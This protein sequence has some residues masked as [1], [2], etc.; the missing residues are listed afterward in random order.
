MK[1]T[2]LSKMSSAKL[3]S[4]PIKQTLSKISHATA[5]NTHDKMLNTVQCV[6][7]R[8]LSKMY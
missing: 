7:T 2:C 5:K 6:R 1:T 3:I 4:K 8:R